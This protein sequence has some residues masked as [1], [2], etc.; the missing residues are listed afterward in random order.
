MPQG[1]IS[2]HLAILK[3]ATLVSDR[4]DGTWVYYSLIDPD[5]GLKRRLIDYLYN[6]RDHLEVV[7]EDLNLLDKLAYAGEICVPR[8]PF[9][10]SSTGS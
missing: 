9:R 1:K 8:P 10:R 3:N 4:R 2:R 6:E 7:I 5:T